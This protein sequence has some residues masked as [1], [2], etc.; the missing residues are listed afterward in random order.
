MDEVHYLSA[1]FLVERSTCISSLS[2][3]TKEKT[4]V[5]QEMSE[6][7]EEPRALTGTSIWHG[8]CYRDF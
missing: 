5:V 1:K 2:Y 3:D 8:Q 4:D 7:S 6:A